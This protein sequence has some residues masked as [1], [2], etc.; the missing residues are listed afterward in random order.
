MIIYR[1]FAS[2][3]QSVSKSVRD[4]VTRAVVLTKSGKGIAMKVVVQHHSNG[5]V[6]FKELMLI[7]KVKLYILLTAC[8]D[9]NQQL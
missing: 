5:D 6:L 7:L 3:E 1:L 4:A 2:T 8:A 9:E